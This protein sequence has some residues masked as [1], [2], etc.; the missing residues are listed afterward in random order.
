MLGVGEE[1]WLGSVSEPK[2]QAEWM[3]QGRLLEPR[4]VEDWAWVGEAAHLG[5]QSPHG[6]RGLFLQSDKPV[7]G[8]SESRQGEE[9]V[10]AERELGRG[11]QSPGEMS[12]V[13]V[14]EGGPAWV[15]TARA[16]VLA[17]SIQQEEHSITSVVFLTET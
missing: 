3:A 15:V 7:C 2:K 5:L 1:G 11:F 4:W 13:S 14:W 10:P 6:G 9:G 16:G 17:P 12:G 8:V